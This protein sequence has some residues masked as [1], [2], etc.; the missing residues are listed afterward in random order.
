MREVSAAAGRLAIRP[1]FTAHPTEAARRSILSKLRA[2]ATELE[3][4]ARAA[5]MDGWT[6]REHD[7]VNVERAALLAAGEVDG[8]PPSMLRLAGQA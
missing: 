2:V 6:D 8:V 3:A 4:E 7:A 1:V 5:A